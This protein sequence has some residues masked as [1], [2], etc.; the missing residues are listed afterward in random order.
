LNHD[1]RREAAREIAEDLMSQEQNPILRTVIRWVLIVGAAV[2]IGVVNVD[3]FRTHMFSVGRVA[4]GQASRDKAPAIAEKWQFAQTG[5]VGAA[6]ALGDDGTV[7]AAS[8]DGFLYAI[9]AAGNLRW[10]FN[11]GP[12]QVAPVLGADDTIYVTNEEQ[13]IFAVNHTGTQ[14]WV[15]G[16]GPYADKRMGAFTAAIDQTHLYTPWRGQLRAVRLTYGTFDWPTGIGYQQ[17]GA[18]SILGD[19]RVVYSGNGRMDVV[20]SA[21]KTQWEYPVMNPPLS[22]DMITKTAG[23]IPPGNFWLDSA[24]AVGDDGTIYACA[25][26]SRLVALTS[27]GHVKWEFKTKTHSVNHGAPVIGADGTINFASGDGFLYAV[28][29]DGV[30]KWAFDAGSGAFSAT[31]VLAQDGTIFV[32][33]DA[34]LFAVSAEGNLLARAVIG[35]SVASSPTIAPDGTVY[36]AGRAG[37]LTAF[38]GT[39]GGLL[40][41]AWPKFQAGPANSGRARG[42]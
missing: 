22:V 36:V 17:G 3:N 25:V 34:G 23:H 32:V 7:Y 39:H 1:T 40:N 5:P 27:D 18:V 38:S 41:S 24:M 16:G 4:P 26:D 15:A 21:G 19:G 6:L 20:D 14:Q 30:Q 31:P 9:D 13:L 8:E 35:G 12:M 42:F 37:K 2:V 28:R 33:N 29:P 11:A 10:K